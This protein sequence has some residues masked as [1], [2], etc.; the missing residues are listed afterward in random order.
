VRRRL[1]VVEGPGEPPASGT[2]LH[3]HGRK[4]GE[5][6]SSARDGGDFVAM[7]MLSLIHLNAAESL[8]LNPE[9]PAR[10]RILR[11]V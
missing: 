11:R 1:H 7:A 2:P 3:Q 6:R 4:V 8:G 5:L 9:D 10:I